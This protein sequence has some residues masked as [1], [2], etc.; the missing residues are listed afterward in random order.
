VLTAADMTNRLTHEANHN[1]RDFSD[2]LADF[3]KERAGFVRKLEAFQDE[4][5]A[6]TALHPRLKKPMRVADFAFFV[7]E[8]DDHHVAA[9]SELIRKFAG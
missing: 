4:T 2:V 5:V 7:A 1:A 8:H 9:I 3:R 6:R